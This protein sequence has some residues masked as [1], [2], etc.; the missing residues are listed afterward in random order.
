MDRD[1]QEVVRPQ[2]GGPAP[3]VAPRVTTGAPAAGAVRRSDDLV[4][5]TTNVVV[6]RDRVRWGPIWAGL[7]AALGTWI[8][9]SVLA[10]AIGAQTVDSTAVDAE[11]A[12]RGSGIASAIIGLLSFLLGGYIAGRTAAIRGPLSGLLHGFLVWALGLLLILALSS[13]GLG[14][15]FGAAGNLVNRFGALANDAGTNLNRERVA[16]NITN[17]AWGALAGLGLPALASTIGGLLGDRTRRSDRS[18]MAF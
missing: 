18:D 3:Q 9:L 16:E 12:S 7:L 6:P 4:Q 13:F 10:L 5:Q 11:T 8:L 2:A 17:G 1:R 14:Q 15:L